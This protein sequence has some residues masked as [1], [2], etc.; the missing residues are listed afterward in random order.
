MFGEIAR[1]VGAA[2]AVV[3]EHP[4][5]RSDAGSRVAGQVH[6]AGRAHRERVGPV[7]GQEQVIE[8]GDRELGRREL[9]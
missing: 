9:A 5:R 1:F 7:D 3:S 4:G 8:V 6:H 2:G